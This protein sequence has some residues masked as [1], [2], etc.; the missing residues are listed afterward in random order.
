MYSDLSVWFGDGRKR[1]LNQ[2]IKQSLLEMPKYFE[3][4]LLSFCLNYPQDVV[5]IIVS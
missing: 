1:R 3:K 5:E 2:L 4:T